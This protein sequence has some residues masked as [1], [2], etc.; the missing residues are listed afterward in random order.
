MT[1]NASSSNPAVKAFFDPDT[2]TVSYVVSDPASSKAAIIDSV[3][4]YDAKSGRTGHKSADALIAYV[5]EQGLDV[6][7]VLETH[8]HA[9][10]LSAAPYLK[11]QLGGQLAIGAN[12]RTVQSVFGDVFNAE[13][14]FRRDGSQFDHLFAD[15]ERFFIGELEARAMHTPGHTPACMTYVI[16]DAAFVGDTLFMP[17]FGTA[18]CDFP[19]G[20]ARTLYRSIQK[21]FALPDETR[22]FMCHDYKAPGRDAYAWEST[23]AE[24]RASNIHVGGGVDEDSFVAMRERR[25]ATLDMPNLILPSVQVNMRAGELPPAEDNGVHYLKIPFDAL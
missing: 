21:I 19:G 23:V 4:D 9:D 13:D 14:S 2:F 16:G 17:D 25:D 18:R 12:I 1:G 7:W 20:D 11:A 22:L 10:H 8:V 15:D 5:K 6:D 3:L 24:E